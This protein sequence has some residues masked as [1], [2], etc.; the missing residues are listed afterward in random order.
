MA[1]ML[2]LLVLRPWSVDEKSLSSSSTIGFVQRASVGSMI[3][4]AG[5]SQPATSHV[6]LQAGDQIAADGTLTIELLDGTTGLLTAN[7]QLLLT[8]NNDL[9]LQHGSLVVIASPRAASAALRVRTRFADCTVVGTRFTVVVNDQQTKLQVDE[10][11]VRFA[12][13][14]DS[15]TL[16]HAGQSVV[17]PKPQTQ[18]KAPEKPN[19][20]GVIGFCL[21]DAKSGVPVPGYELMTG[22][23]TLPYA[24]SRKPLGLLALTNPTHIG[25]L[26]FRYNALAPQSVQVNPPYSLTPSHVLSGN[27]QF[28]PLK[29]RPGQHVISATPQRE[30]VA[31]TL[32]ITVLGATP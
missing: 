24:L 23:V 3:M 8:A 32:T 21:I 14:N 18:V 26:Q 20:I 25:P 22:S 13:V 11:I 17:A 2:A 5:I 30:G 10:G 28:E 15:A 4:R 19:T 9:H 27:E 1:A 16:V 7:A 6:A 31:K 12:P 29:L